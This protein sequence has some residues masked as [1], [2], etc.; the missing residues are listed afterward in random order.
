MGKRHLWHWL[1]NRWWEHQA[2]KPRRRAPHHHAPVSTPVFGLADEA[3]W[4][5]R[6]VH[7]W[8]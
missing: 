8:Y 4:R 3:S 7:S 1:K 6:S 2:F 5:W